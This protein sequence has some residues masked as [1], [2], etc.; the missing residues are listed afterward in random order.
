MYVADPSVW[1]AVALTVFAK[2]RDIDP[3]IKTSWALNDLQQIFE[4]EA[5]L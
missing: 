5:A 3:K 4:P 1:T 2:A